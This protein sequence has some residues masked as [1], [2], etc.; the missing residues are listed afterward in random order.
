MSKFACLIH[1]LS[2]EL[3]S[4]FEPAVKNKREDL[5]KKIFEWSKP[6]L[7]SEVTGLR[8]LTGKESEGAL[9]LYNVLPEQLLSMDS[10]FLL[11]RVIE[12]GKIAEGYGAKIFGLAAYTA[13]VG[14]RGVLVAKNLNIP[15]TTGTSYTIF[16]VIESILKAAKELNMDL[17]EINLAMIGATGAIGRISAQI[18]SNFIPNIILVGRNKQKLEIVKQSIQV[19]G[20][21]KNVYLTDDIKSA[22][23]NADIVM[24]ATNTPYTLID[25]KEVQPGTLICDVSLPRNVKQDSVDAREDVLVIDGGIVKPPGSVNFNFSYG[26]P[27]GL[28]YACMAETMIL[29]LEE[30]FEYFSLGGDITLYKVKEIGELAKKHGFKLS[31]FRSFNREVSNSHLGTVRE[32]Y[33]NKNKSRKKIKL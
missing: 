32:A 17:K 12:A 8:S 14:K 19:D 4:T 28:C 13:Q 21:K 26:L 24:T 3:F 30:R 27:A 25:I 16:I 29:A 10:D 1:P 20:N 9:I 5:V 6:K 22:L 23:N 7:V 11:G 33:L 15:I 2:I 18:L 31:E